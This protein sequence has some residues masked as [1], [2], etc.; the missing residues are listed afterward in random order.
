M[1]AEDAPG[2]KAFCTQ[3]SKYANGPRKHLTDA[4]L[5]PASNARLCIC[6]GN[7]SSVQS[8]LDELHT[9][10][11]D[12]PRTLPALMAILQQT[13][14]KNVNDEVLRRDHE[15]KVMNIK[16]SFRDDVDL[17]LSCATSKD[18]RVRGTSLLIIKEW[19]QLDIGAFA[20]EDDEFRYHCLARAFR[21]KGPRLIVDMLV[22]NNPDEIEI[23][24]HII[25][26]S[27]AHV[28][29]RNEYIQL[30]AFKPIM[31]YVVPVNS[32]TIR[33]LALDALTHLSTQIEQPCTAFLRRGAHKQDMWEVV[34]TEMD[35][36]AFKCCRICA[37]SCWKYDRPQ[38]RGV[39][40]GVCECCLSTAD[41]CN[42]IPNRGAE[43]ATMLGVANAA[44]IAFARPTTEEDILI[45]ALK[46]IIAN[47]ERPFVDVGSRGFGNFDAKGDNVAKTKFNPVGKRREII[48]D[49]KIQLEYSFPIPKHLLYKQTTIIQAVFWLTCLPVDMHASA[50]WATKLDQDKLPYPW[51][52]HKAACN[53]SALRDYAIK[54]V[55]AISPEPKCSKRLFLPVL[56]QQQT[57]WIQQRSESSSDS[58]D[59]EDERVFKSDYSSDDFDQHSSGG[60]YDD[61]DKCGSVEN[62]K[63]GGEALDT[64]TGNA[65]EDETF[66]GEKLHKL[67]E[68]LLEGP[69]RRNSCHLQRP[70]IH[71]QPIMVRSKLNGILDRSF[72]IYIKDL[73]KEAITYRYPIGHY[74][75]TVAFF[76]TIDGSEPL[77]ELDQKSIREYKKATTSNEANGQVAEIPRRTTNVYYGD[78][79]IYNKHGLM[80]FK[81]VSAVVPANWS[82]ISDELHRVYNGNLTSRITQKSKTAT[83]RKMLNASI[84]RNKE[85]LKAVVARISAINFLKKMGG[86]KNS[87]SSLE[88]E[89]FRKT[90]SDNESD[91]PSDYHQTAVNA[92]HVRLESKRKSSSSRSRKRLREEVSQRI[93]LITIVD[94]LLAKI[95]ENP[96]SKTAIY[97]VMTLIESGMAF[98]NDLSVLHN[99][100]QLRAHNVAHVLS[101]FDVNVVHGAPIPSSSAL[102]TGPEHFD[103]EDRMASVRGLSRE[104]GAGTTTPVLE[105]A[106]GNRFMERRISQMILSNAVSVLGRS[107]DVVRSYVAL[108]MPPC[109]KFLTQSPQN[110]VRRDIIAI[111]GFFG[112]LPFEDIVRFVISKGL[113]RWIVIEA[114]DLYSGN[115]T[116]AP[117]GR[118]DGA[119]LEECMRTIVIYCSHTMCGDEF[120]KS[121]GIIDEQ[122]SLSTSW[123]AEVH[124]P[125]FG[126]Y[127]LRFFRQIL[128]RVQNILVDDLEELAALGLGLLL[129]PTS[130]LVSQYLKR[131]IDK[132][133][134]TTATIIHLV[135]T[136]GGKEGGGVSDV[137]DE[138]TSANKGKKELYG[139]TPDSEYAVDL[140]SI[141]K[142]VQ[143]VSKHGDNLKQWL[144]CACTANLARFPSIRR[145]ICK[146]QT[147][148]RFINNSMRQVLSYRIHDLSVSLSPTLNATLVISRLSKDPSGV[149]LWMKFASQSRLCLDSSG[150][151]SPAIKKGTMPLHISHIKDDT[152][153]NDERDK[154]RHSWGATFTSH[155]SFILHQDGIKLPAEF[156]ISVWFLGGPWLQMGRIYTLLQSTNG[157]KVICLDD[158]GRIGS[159]Q[160]GVGDGDDHSL[161]AHWH[162]LGVSLLD[163]DG[164]S[165]ATGTPL[166][167]SSIRFDEET[168][169]HLVVMGYSR[170]LGD[171]DIDQPVMD[172]FIDRKKLGDTL[173]GYRPTSRIFC[174]GNTFEGGENWGTI[175]DFRLYP[176]VFA[177][178]TADWPA[179]LK[180]VPPLVPQPQLIGHSGITSHS[181][182]RVDSS[183]K[184]SSSPEIDDIRALLCEIN[185][186]PNI[187][188]LL[189]NESQEAREIGCMA[190][191][192]MALFDRGRSILM[193]QWVTHVADTNSEWE[194]KQQRESLMRK[195]ADACIS[196]DRLQ[197]KIIDKSKGSRETT[198]DQLQY[199]V[200]FEALETLQARLRNLEEDYAFEMS[201]ERERLLDALT[202]LSCADN[203]S[204]VRK[205]ASK[206][207]ANM[208]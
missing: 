9:V 115:H 47:C 188:A 167:S 6:M 35:S 171:G 125:D 103:D 197:S 106:D 187:V 186:I 93:T 205:A 180:Y 42:H 96:M 78:P 148:M 177:Q 143:E 109:L 146:N 17:I 33:T 12:V 131:E 101:N 50:P 28:N 195:I 98:I 208:Y 14:T 25:A 130:K 116:G 95:E 18:P 23:L 70:F 121:G 53:S 90:D 51:Y 107:H 176:S 87:K 55:W 30:M 126:Y 200:H 193:R 15:V 151:F 74:D 145:S 157:D 118:A 13:N 16:R 102:N 40:V 170:K 174:L 82:G 137:D 63:L 77:W 57:S 141:F 59:G 94:S 204:S 117:R 99:L 179:H 46:L 149:Y 84:A 134:R 60:D 1:S 144:C 43:M 183:Q 7:E 166:K 159:L 127:L 45:A 24:L 173:I 169:H 64:K 11:T 162:C 104:F 26:L 199:S 203:S 192:N 132:K 175:A 206:A 140:L 83:K 71:V 112:M 133:P 105:H 185:C 111:I 73:K 158:Q 62:A 129:Q 196:V 207:L 182:N 10:G 44:A 79:I 100:E 160:A 154:T 39:I 54:A 41:K 4:H 86:T 142:V 202:R 48:A 58:S 5:Y 20:S 128:R 156:T 165:S 172:F 150:N 124:N 113:L 66:R 27:S 36:K 89:G 168:W 110:I 8:P 88:A 37:F 65:L 189:G 181:Q 32:N 19:F 56:H 3:I 153:E 38:Y 69:L 164:L 191:A 75:P 178:N 201:M 138:S 194:F 31:L 114:R 108:I 190:I 135:G 119:L 147:V 29:L 52:L 97:S 21:P 123:E 2:R 61:V 80:T 49:F 136:A 92:M 81:A 161:W 34:S 76:Y 91:D 72:A 152:S 85:R 22:Q 68:A 198:H 67:K 139:I 120:R 184:G 122:A 163:F 155:D